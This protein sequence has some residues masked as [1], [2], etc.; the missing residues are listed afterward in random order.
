MS[1]RSKRSHMNYCQ[2]CRRAFELINNPDYCENCRI[3]LGLNPGDISDRPPIVEE[4]EL[5]FKKYDRVL[6]EWN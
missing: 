2:E 4:I 1:K 3:I 5:A 6:Q